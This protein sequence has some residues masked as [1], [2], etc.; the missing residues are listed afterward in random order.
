MARA[1]NILFS[2]LSLFL[3]PSC[4]VSASKRASIDPVPYSKKINP[5]APWIM[6][7]HV[8]YQ[9]NFLQDA[10]LRYL[11]HLAI[12][13]AFPNPDGTINTTFD[14]DATQGPIWAKSLVKKAKDFDLIT[15]GFLGGSTGSEANADGLPMQQRWLLAT[16]N[17]PLFAK[18]LV[19]FAEEYGFDGL[20]LDW[21]PIQN[22]EIPILINLATE[23]KKINPRLLLSFPLNWLNPNI[24]K[25]SPL[26]KKAADVFDRLNIMSYMMTVNSFGWKSWHSSALYGESGSTPSSVEAS[27]KM[28]LAAGI[29]PEKLGVGAAY[30]GQ[31]YSGSGIEPS[32]ELNRFK[33]EGGDTWLPQRKIAAYYK[34]SPQNP[35][36]MK[37]N[38]DK[39]AQAP[40]LNSL[41]PVGNNTLK[42]YDG[43]NQQPYKCNYITYEDEESLKQKS[44][45]IKSKQ[46]G[47][48]I[49]WTIAQGDVSLTQ[50]ISEHIK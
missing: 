17:T 1:Q 21:E 36:G 25:A 24:D 31:C 27:A 8:G 22:S 3:F 48:I 19:K 12:G 41:K 37:Y 29:P 9:K 16:K 33:F 35:N 20:D 14:I 32:Q 23:I 40:F 44:R 7:Y 50:T 46:L 39:N 5:K 38:Y 42:A 11:S 15:I 47:G 13:R 28:Y 10:H 6:G 26:W 49:I 43:G 45:Y 34:I 4:F 2:V 30:E 18:N